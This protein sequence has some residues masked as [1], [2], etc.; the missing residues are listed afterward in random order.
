MTVSSL[1]IFARISVLVASVDGSVEA[2]HNSFFMDSLSAA[3]QDAN[4]RWGAGEAVA[5]RLANGVLPGEAAAAAALDA[6][7]ARGAD[8]DLTG[9]WA[10]HPRGPCWSA[11]ASPHLRHWWRLAKLDCPHP[12]DHCSCAGLPSLPPPRFTF[13]SQAP[14]GPP[15]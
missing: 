4:E 14:S 5:C 13:S 8:A 6:D 7:V 2:G 11:K 15:G 12:Q 3:T 1:L 9:D 10:E